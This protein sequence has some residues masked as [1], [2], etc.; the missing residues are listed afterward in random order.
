[1]AGR[2]AAPGERRG[3]R[4]KGTPNK[5]TAARQSAVASSGL[6]PL[7]YMLNVMRDEEVEPVRRDWA[8]KAVAPY[9]HP[10]LSSVQTKVS[11]TLTLEQLVAG[12]LPVPAV[13]ADEETP[14]EDGK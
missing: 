6:T 11:G 13:P 10:T 1:M 9:V 14:K 4:A 12:S 5:A 2:G 8:A 7:E 3:G